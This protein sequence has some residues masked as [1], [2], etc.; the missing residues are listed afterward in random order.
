[1]PIV[2]TLSNA[3]NYAHV[4]E[5]LGG[6]SSITNPFSHAKGRAI[7]VPSNENQSAPVI[8]VH[9][10]FIKHPMLVLFV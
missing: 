3:V 8:G 1:M 6:S 9:V 4:H 5:T 10:Q 7:K 2:V